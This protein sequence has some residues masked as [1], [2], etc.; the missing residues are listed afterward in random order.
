MITRFVLVCSLTDGAVTD[1]CSQWQNGRRGQDGW[2]RWTRRRKWYRDA[3]LVEADAVEEVPA[4]GNAN[5]P[6]PSQTST[7]STGSGAKHT[8]HSDPALTT[9]DTA[10]L[11]RQA[12]DDREREDEFDDASILSTSSRSTRFKSSLRRRMVSDTSNANA[13]ASVLGA[14]PSSR[15]LSQSMQSRRASAAT[16]EDDTAALGTRIGLALQDA[17]KEE[18]SWGVGDEV[19]MGLE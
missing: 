19:R 13:G 17:G 4:N 8:S 10:D 9:T 5:G 15:S 12:E 2:G 7:L 14:S 6:V 18:G 3:E 16:S 11:A 1:T